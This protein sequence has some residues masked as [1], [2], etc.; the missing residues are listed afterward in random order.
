MQAHLIKVEW[1]FGPTP[2]CGWMWFEI[3]IFIYNRL[4]MIDYTMIICGYRDI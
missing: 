4:Q 2:N 1:M 3:N